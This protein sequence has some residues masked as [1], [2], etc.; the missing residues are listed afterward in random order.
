MA[1]QHQEGVEE[2]Q[3][4]D[5]SLP[6]LASSAEV[7][8]KQTFAGSLWT[9]MLQGAQVLHQVKTVAVQLQHFGLGTSWSEN[10]PARKVFNQMNF[11]LVGYDITL[12]KLL[13]LLTDQSL[14]QN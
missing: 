9:A 13:R 7:W 11:S 3:S 6:L 8:L 14:I 5:D 1:Q 10:L 2:Q 4:I 12:Y